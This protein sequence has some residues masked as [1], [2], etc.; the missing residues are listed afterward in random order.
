MSLVIRWLKPTTT[1]YAHCDVPCGIYDPHQAELAA[2]DGYQ[3]AL[4]EHARH[5]AAPRQD[6]GV[7]VEKIGGQPTGAARA[8]GRHPT[9]PAVAGDERAR[10]KHGR[11]A[12]HDPA[13]SFA[14]EADLP[15][16]G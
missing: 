10:R 2:V 8:A 1:V 13:L 9:L 5:A 12:P 16:G 3:L 6:G 15:Q 14:A 7:R 11:R 4:A